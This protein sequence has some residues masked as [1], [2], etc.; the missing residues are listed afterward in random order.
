[1]S[2]YHCSK[3]EVQRSKG[4]NAI[5]SGA[6]ISRSKLTFTYF[7]K[8]SGQEIT[9]TFDYS[10]REGLAHS[11]IIAPD[12]AP[13]WAYDRQELWNKAEAAETRIN[14]ET[15]RKLIIALPKELTLE[16]NIELAREFAR[17]HLVI[18]GMVADVNVHYDNEDNP[19]CHIQM[20]TR[21]LEELPSGEYIFG[22]KGR[23]WGRR[24]FLMFYRE[25]VANVIN[26]HL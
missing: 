17:E 24:D 15:A 3:S 7:D 16:Q 26:K 13:D 21:M 18:H 4:H 5:A 20:T 14:S 19:H 1:M 8:Q 22:A 25:S 11:E 2:T 10:T 6:Y 12:Y 9:T 23:D